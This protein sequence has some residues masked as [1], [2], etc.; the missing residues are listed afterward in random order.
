[1]FLDERGK[2]EVQNRFK[3]LVSPVKIKYF[4]QTLNCDY[5]QETEQLLR[6]VADLSNL[7][8]LEVKNLQLDAEEAA[9]FGVDRA[10]AIVIMGEEDYGIRFFGIPSGYE[11]V[12]LL[13][14]IL[15]V[16]RRDSGLSD[17]AKAEIAAIDRP[18]HLQVFVTPTCPYCPR[19]VI[20]AHQYAMANPNIRADMVEATE[21]PMLAQQYEVM[22]VPRT[23]VNGRHYIDGGLP[24]EAFRQQLLHFL[25]AEKAE[26]VN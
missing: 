25:Q 10:P 18:V 16:S 19:A 20:T 3:E 1:M 26:A 2:Q 6:E 5:C 24:E 7:I 11:F 9:A 12:S 13:E 8:E 4:T 15:S 21:F 14:A 23:V 22:G 17:A